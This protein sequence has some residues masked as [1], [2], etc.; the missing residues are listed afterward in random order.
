MTLLSGACSGGSPPPGHSDDPVA[1]ATGEQV[2]CSSCALSFRRLSTFPQGDDDTL[3]GFRAQLVVL[4]SGQAVVAPVMPSGGIAR[5]DAAGHLDRVV[6][7]SGG[8]PGELGDVFSLAPSAD[9]LLVAARD[10]ISLFSD[11]L[12]PIREAPVATV[13]WVVRALGGGAFAASSVAPDRSPTLHILNPDLTLRRSFGVLPPDAP[14]ERRPLAVDARAQ[15]WA[16]VPGQYALEHWDASGTLL[17]TIGRSVRFF[18]AWTT[19]DAFSRNR[20]T[21]PPLPRVVDLYSA[22]SE[23]WVLL[24]VA[25]ADWKA[26]AAPAGEHNPVPSLAAV[27]RRVDRL[28]EVLDAMSGAAR[29]SARLPMFAIS[30]GAAGQLVSMRE[31]SAGIRRFDEWAVTVKR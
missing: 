26:E 20:Y 17:K 31:D 5:F 23:L 12:L 4:A 27:E 28:L 19:R 22:G 29:V 25:D 3:F 2:S 30:F 21:Q 1:T 15:I 8:G 13:Y 18:P 6:G 16:A 10:R 14:P 9:S 7:R 24:E 11:E